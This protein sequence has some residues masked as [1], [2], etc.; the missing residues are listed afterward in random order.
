MKWNEE[1]KLALL[2]SFHLLWGLV[3]WF[4]I[5]KYGL[6][7]S[8][9]S[10]DFLFG[11]L[12]LSSGKGLIT[13]DGSFLLL[14]PPLYPILL[15]LIHLATGMEIFSS[16]KL[17]QAAAFIGTS[18]CL[19]ILFR[20]MFPDNFLFA[21]A[22]NILADI[23]VV[24]LISFTTIG[25]DYVFFF[26]SVLFLLLTG[27]YIEDKSPGTLLA[28]SAVGILAMLQRYLGIAVI[29]TGVL[30][31]FFL[32]SCSRWQRVIRGLMLSLSALPA[33]LWLAVTSGLI[34]RRAPISFEEN[35]TWFSKSILEWFFRPDG[36]EAHLKVYIVLL[37]IFITGLIILTMV[38]RL[39]SASP[40]TVPVLVFG[41]VY[42]L[43]LF[44][45][46]SAAYYNKL[47][48]RFLLPLYFP[49]V[50]LLI[51]TA[52]NLV[53]AFRSSNVHFAR[54]SVSFISLGGITLAA[55][56]LLHNTIPVVL[57]SHANGAAGG[58]NVF[59][60]TTWHKNSALN[61]LL[62]HPPQGN[63]VLFSNY[64]DA[65]AFYTH[66]PCKS[67]PRK[68]S[69]PYGKKEFPVSQ[70][71]DELFPSKAE[72]YLLWIEPNLY[73]YMYRVD[74]LASIARIEPLFVSRDG[75]VYL[76]TPKG[77]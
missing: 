33:G 50:T 75:G 2:M 65:A 74:D 41:L 37:W 77:N 35:F 51:V 59:N 57:A 38:Y 34:G 14:W 16:A 44:G 46:A 73:S 48:G 52:A 68:Y 23:G 20:K 66:Q 47:G 12:N 64:P 9:D 25:S 58:E 4:S 11:A 21:L 61:Y 53:K 67:S 10:V 42:C 69:G 43:A 28:M 70:Y 15:A 32:A 63:Y 49:F 54:S 17:L 18:L 62:S 6:G 60:N 45:S 71:K 30:A 22:G 27:R 3:L 24:V 40:Y 76:L 29:A 39:Q 5:S 31:T 72:A 19:A 13:F 56:L 36:V 55:A 1:S 8:T 26:L 7:V